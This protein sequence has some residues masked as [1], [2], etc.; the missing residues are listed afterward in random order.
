[1][2][3]TINCYS[4]LESI[5]GIR[6]FISTVKRVHHNSDRGAHEHVSHRDTEASDCADKLRAEMP[7]G[8]DDLRGA[9]SQYQLSAHR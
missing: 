6:Q 2:N 5:S 9:L 7:R 3:I 1:M 4:E 8:E